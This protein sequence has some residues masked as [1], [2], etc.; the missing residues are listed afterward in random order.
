MVVCV[1]V[2]F[3]IIPGLLV[4]VGVLL[5]D[6]YE[7]W[8][9]NSMDK[10]DMCGSSLEVSHSC[11]DEFYGVILVVCDAC[12]NNNIVHAENEDDLDPYDIYGDDS[13]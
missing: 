12:H 8:K 7:Q 2:L 4:M 9:E 3:I 5:Y 13:Q 10:C 6:M 1:M 11:H